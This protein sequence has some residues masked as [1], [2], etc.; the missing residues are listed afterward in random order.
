MT[1]EVDGISRRL[2]PVE[3]EL[4]FT[5]RNRLR[6]EGE[7]HLASGVGPDVGLLPDDLFGG[8]EEDESIGREVLPRVEHEGEP[9][10][11]GGLQHRWVMAADGSEGVGGNVDLGAVDPHVI[12][13]FGEEPERGGQEGGSESGSEEGASSRMPEEPCPEAGRDGLLG[14]LLGDVGAQGFPEISGQLDL[15]EALFTTDEVVLETLSA[16]NKP[17]STARLP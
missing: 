14:D 13:T 3:P 11:G 12:S 15:V 5:A 17:N 6:W 16:S 8:V 4:V 7:D 2:D 10:P 9:A 1:L